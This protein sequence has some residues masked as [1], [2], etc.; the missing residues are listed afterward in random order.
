M[1]VP[2]SNLLLMALT[3]LG[4]TPV[5]Y[6]KYSARVAN[7]GGVYLT[8]YLAPVTIVE[9]SVQAVDR[10]KY[11]Q[12]GLDFEKNYVSWFVPEVDAIDLARDVSGDAIEVLGRRWQLMGST[13]WFQVDGW[14]SLMGV[15]IGPATGSITNA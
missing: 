4:S 1:S 6:L 7:A 15:D 10:S 5:D 12:Y 14:K 9:G 3:V 11:V 2:G 8:T 13:D